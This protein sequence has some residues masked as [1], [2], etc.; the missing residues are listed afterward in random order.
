MFFASLLLFTLPILGFFY[1][2]LFPK[3][4]LLAYPFSRTLVTFNK[5]W[6][7]VK[8]SRDERNLLHSWRHGLIAFGFS[9]RFRFYRDVILK[10]PLRNWFLPSVT[11]TDGMGHLM[12]E[13]DRQVTK[14]EKEMSEY[15]QSPDSKKDLLQ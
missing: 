8:K 13:A 3:E 15:S 12:G 2:L 1:I 5:T 14:R 6:G 4:K 9:T 7:F 10:S 11:N